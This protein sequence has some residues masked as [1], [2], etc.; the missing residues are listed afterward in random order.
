MAIE[1]KYETYI[2][3]IPRHVLP[4][5][6]ESMIPIDHYQRSV[7]D[8]W[9][10][11]LYAIKNFSKGTYPAASD[12]HLQSLRV[13]VLLSLMEAFERF[14]KE[15][16]ATCIDHVHPYVLDDRLNVFMVR[17][18]VLASHFAGSSL[19][20]AL[21]EPL[22]WC[23]SDLANDRF[24]RILADPNRTDLNFYLFPKNLSQNPPTLRG[25]YELMEVVWQLRHA[26]VHNR[27]LLTASDAR[28]LRVLCKMSV[29]GPNRLNPTKADVWYVKL[30]L[31]DLA[32]KITQAVSARLAELLTD[33]R[34]GDPTLFDAGAK[35]QEL[36]NLF[37]RL[38]TISGQT[39]NPT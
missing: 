1:V 16:A 25:R 15:T 5:L 18:D 10:L 6:A 12:R 2:P 32:D 37:Q 26:I 31:D 39:R 4:P 17:G 20:K 35:A 28:K 38:V 8:A 36:V 13:M 3:R 14:L 23:D 33:L 21:C 22:T 24:R 9:N 30:F 19:G 29:E 11:L 34:S 7:D 27:G